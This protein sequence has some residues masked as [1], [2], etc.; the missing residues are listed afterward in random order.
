MTAP[1]SHEPNMETA[2]T[3]WSELPAKWTP[4]GWKEHLFR[5]NM[6]YN[7]MISAMPDLNRRSAEWKGQGVQLGV[8]PSDKVDFPGHVIH[9]QDN[10]NVIQGWLEEEAPV[11]WSEW[12]QDGLLLRETA[13]AHI[14]GGRAIETGT[15]PLFAWI[16]FSIHDTLQALPIP[17]SFGFNLNLNAPYIK[18][19]AM[20]IRYNI[21]ITREDS[22]YPRTLAAESDTYDPNKGLRILEPDGK[23]RFAIAPGHKGAVQILPGKPTDRD[24]MIYLGLTPRKG[25]YVDVL[26][27]MI[28]TDREVFDREMALGY[29]G[30]LAE[31]NAFWSEK[32][33]T[34]ARFDTPERQVNEAINQ[35]IRMTQI[36]ADRDPVSGF[37]SMVTGTWTYA[38][39]WATPAAMQYVMLLD[40]MGYHD[41]V[42]K[43]MRMYTEIQGT[44]LPVGDYFTPHPGSLGSPKC[45]EACTWTSDH[46]AILWGLAQ[47]A[48]TTG[49]DKYNKAITEPILKACEF[50]R[51]ARRITGHGGVEGLMPPGVATDMPTKI[52]SVWADAWNHKG[53]ITAIRFLKRIN[54]PR[55]A[56]FEAEAKDYRETFRKAIKAATASMPA[57]TDDE[58]N[59]HRLVPMA[60]YGAQPFEYRNAF[61]LDTGP[62]CLVF[63]GLLDADDELM[64]STLKWFRS[65]PPTKV[66][67]YDADCW[68]VPSLCHEM[69][70]CEPCFSWNVFHNHQLN[71]RYHYLEG[72]Y[73]LFAG[74][75]SRQ[76]QTVCETRG[77]VTGCAGVH[78]PV[79]LARLAVLDDQIEENALHLL[80]VMPL[81]WLRSDRESIFEN[82]STEFGP[83]TLRAGLDPTG[84][85]L[86]L[87]WQPKFRINPDR[88]VLHIP[89]VPGL[90]SLV[91]NGKKSS[92]TSGMK[93]TL[94]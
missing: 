80:R 76:T 93:E 61:Y 84:T 91:I 71:D 5:F 77:G 17:E 12:A 51:D 35:S 39:V 64:R 57:W 88:V 92:V 33:A 90:K 48:L 36:G 55:A 87:T 53:L 21:A 58:G 74:A 65:G 59:E 67:R 25:A 68:Q 13:F 10:G 60:V 75:V 32:P 8:F 1:V 82:L 42:E 7:G 19:G 50:I 20:S 47:H 6:L 83:V 81:A 9:P 4:F 22:A 70:S 18:T 46:G 89:P 56:E 73:C 85:E 11:L 16:R 49:S 79:Y 78:L 37:Y 94:I 14:P 24:F 54:H 28:P 23:V 69:S 38:D 66:Y 72:M 86:R 62:L 26:L 45:Y 41:L 31:A 2:F 30:A 40:V 29:D 34:L 3:W 52:Q 15:E 27:P 43:Y 44:V 63:S